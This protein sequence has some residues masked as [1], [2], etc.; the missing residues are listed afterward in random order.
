LFL[1]EYIFESWLDAWDDSAYGQ[2][3]TA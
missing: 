3:T 2:S 1:S